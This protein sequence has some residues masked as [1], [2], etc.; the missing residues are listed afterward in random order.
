MKEFLIPVLLILS[1]VFGYNPQDENPSEVDP[2]QR[3]L[4]H[5]PNAASLG[6]Y[7]EMPVNEH[8]GVPNINVPVYTLQSGDLTLPVS[9][10]YHATGLKVDDVASWVGAGWSL[11]AGGVINRRIMGIPD[12]Q[13]VC[14][15]RGALNDFFQDNPS[16]YSGLNDFAAGN[17]LDGYLH[18]PHHYDLRSILEGGLCFDTAPDI[19]T[20][21]VNGLTGTFVFNS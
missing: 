7:G 8:T 17:I 1:T 12:N 4:P 15:S 9:L 14:G 20:F 2:I 16:G 18:S 11:N 13:D 5:S 19:F 6:Q 3:H 10:S 21:N